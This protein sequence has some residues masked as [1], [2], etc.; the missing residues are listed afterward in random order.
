MR[1]PTVEDSPAIHICQICQ[2]DIASGLD[3]KG[4]PKPCKD[5]DRLMRKKPSR[6]GR[7]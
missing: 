2:D 5:C 1:K 3:P 4:F 6:K 7:K